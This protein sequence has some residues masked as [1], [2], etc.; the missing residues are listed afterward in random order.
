MSSI[1]SVVFQWILSFSLSSEQKYKER[2]RLREC[3]EEIEKKE[4]LKL[5][6]LM[7]EEL[8]VSSHALTVLRGLI[9]G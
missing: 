6:H 9:Y 1:S 2:D 4:E 5:K 8:N 7:C 3:F